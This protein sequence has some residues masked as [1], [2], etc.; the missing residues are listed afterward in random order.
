MLV[1]EL[2][3][4]LAG[5][6]NT[7]Q[8]LTL[9]QLSI[10]DDAER[11]SIRDRD[12]EDLL[13]DEQ[14]ERALAGY[15]GINKTYLAKCPPELKA[16]NLN[17]WLST[18][19]NT[20]AVVDISARN[21]VSIHQPGILLLPLHSV[22]EIIVRTF[23]P[24]DEVV[25]LIRN[26][27]KFHIDIKTDHH[28]EV[29]PD[30]RIQGRQ[31]GDITHGGV[32]I[33]ATPNE[34]KAPEV[35]TYLHR[36]WCTNGCT[37]PT[38]ESTIRLRAHTLP[39]ILEELENAA[40]AVL[41]GMDEK[42]ASYAATAE[43]AV[44]G[45]TTG[46]IYQMARESD[47]PANITDRL[48]SHAARLPE[49]SSLYDVLNIFTEAANHGNISYDRMSSLQGISGDMAF[50]SERVVHRCSSCERPLPEL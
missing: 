35:R 3:E 32:R 37:S 38:A 45:S 25:T 6:R 9:G 28:V 20:E 5:R 21:L 30:E 49:D 7:Q 42:L 33:L 48:M 8:E 47:M 11:I 15:L 17:H 16:L 43:I 14:A 40:Q 4:T 23:Q 44:P 29:R 27:E 19:R 46:F 34:K 41:A 12:Q 2:T 18:K 50:N 36:L 1:E 22:A 24:T 13:L 39:E 10:S 26:E 31:V